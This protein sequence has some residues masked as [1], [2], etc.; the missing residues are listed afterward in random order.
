MVGGGSQSAAP[1]RIQIAHAHNLLITITTTTNNIATTPI[2]L[3]LGP[4]QNHH[5]INSHRPH[6][7]HQHAKQYN[8]RH[9]IPSSLTIITSIL[10]IIPSIHQ[11]HIIPHLAMIPN[12]PLHTYASWMGFVI[13][14]HL[15]ALSVIRTELSIRGTRPPHEGRGAQRGGFVLTHHPRKLRRRGSHFG[16]EFITVAVKSGTARSTLGA[17]ITRSQ[18]TGWIGGRVPRVTAIVHLNPAF[19][20]NESIDA[21]TVIAGFVSL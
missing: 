8:P 6:G 1:I 14:H 17:V 7:N 3:P 19:V 9:R 15:D 12:P 4:N 5:N 16:I 11:Q 13:A 21:F 18:Y 10:R 20:T 2:H